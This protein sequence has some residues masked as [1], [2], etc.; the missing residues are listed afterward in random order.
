MSA[1]HL[2]FGVCLIVAGAIFA[3]TAHPG[4]AWAMGILGGVYWCTVVR[5]VMNDQ[6]NADAEKTAHEHTDRR[7]G[8]G[9]PSLKAP[10]S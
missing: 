7:Q 9:A 1:I 4:L 10:K 8:P 2:I 6:A 3:N 5:A